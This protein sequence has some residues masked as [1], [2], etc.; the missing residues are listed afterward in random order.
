MEQYSEINK[1]NQ[2]TSSEN[3]LNEEFFAWIKSDISNL[4]NEIPQNEIL[5]EKQ[6]FFSSLREFMNSITKFKNEKKTKRKKDQE[7]LKYK[8]NERYLEEKWKDS[9]I[10]FTCEPSN[11]SFRFTIL[12]EKGEWYLCWIEK[13]NGLITIFSIKSADKEESLRWNNMMADRIWII[14]QNNEISTY[15]QHSEEDLLKAKTAILGYIKRI[16]NITQ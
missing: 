12:S 13:S 15:A 9:Y 7:T 16:K 3:Q 8:K 5:W 14:K 1:Y 2:L 4:K 10:K 11:L 6:D